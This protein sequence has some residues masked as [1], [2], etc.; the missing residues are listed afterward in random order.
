MRGARFLPATC[1]AY[2]SCSAGAVSINLVVISW[3]RSLP[4]ALFDAIVKTATH[5]QNGFEPVYYDKH[6]ALAE[7]VKAVSR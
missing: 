3:I 5:V 7:P 6:I 1:S 2:V 4:G